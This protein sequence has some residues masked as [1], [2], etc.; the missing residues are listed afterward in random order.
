[1][2]EKLETLIG[3]LEISIARY[4]HELEHVQTV[5]ELWYYK[6]MA[7]G[8]ISTYG[9]TTGDKL[10]EQTLRHAFIENWFRAQERVLNR[11]NNPS[12]N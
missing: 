8:D 10:K 9:L 5:E 11:L 2:N 1:M 7:F 3:V 12:T 4:N 6:G